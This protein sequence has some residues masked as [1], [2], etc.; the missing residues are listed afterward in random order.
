VPLRTSNYEKWEYYLDQARIYIA[1]DTLS[2][3]MARY[4]F[5]KGTFLF[6][7]KQDYVGTAIQFQL[8]KRLNPG[9]ENFQNTINSNLTNLY[10]QIKL[11]D[12][13]ETLIEKELVFSREKSDRYSE[14]FCL[15]GL[16]FAVL[17]LKKFDK[18]KEVCGDIF[19]LR[20][21][22]GISPAFGY[23]YYLLGEYYLGMNQL[24]SAAQIFQTGFAFSEKREEEKE[25]IDCLGG[26][27]RVN[28]AKEQYD[29]AIR[30]GELALT[31]DHRPE[32]HIEKHLASAYQEVGR[33][34]DAYELLLAYNDKNNTDDLER[35]NF[36]ITEQ[37]VEERFERDKKQV[38]LVYEQNLNQQ[39]YNFLAL[40]AFIALLLGLLTIILQARSRRRLKE[41][42]QSLLES[43]ESLRQFAYITSHDLKE[44]VRNI[45]SFSNLL[46]RRLS[47]KENTNDE[48]DFLTFIT[49]NA[50]VL[51]EIV[52]SL[53]IFT[54][55]SFGK[56]EKE[57][58]N[59]DEVFALLEN[60]L[61]QTIAEKN[62]VL[63][64]HESQ[65]IQ[66]I[67]FSRSMLILVLQNLI[68][69]GFKY[70]QSTQPR[71]E[72]AV[73]NSKGRCLMT[74]KDNGE[75]IESA[76]FEKI[77]KPFKTLKNKS[78]TQSSGLGLSICKNILERYNGRI[79]VES[80]GKNGS[81][82]FVLI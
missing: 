17:E 80:D 19:E 58:V 59:L 43:N 50:I 51:K 14:L 41:L 20:E 78:L 67:D 60:G 12:R 32:H 37:L 6:E 25:L 64:F 81:T 8:A 5:H 61:Q 44:P 4:H 57:E 63:L 33:Y 47:Q 76:Y 38:A 31:Y 9:D 65:E 70:N 73:K 49:S 1:D 39:R 34:K 55:I 22:T 30:N 75:G 72:V 56:I 48:K 26:I 62:G 77:F 36:I 45:T 2:N 7:A 15:Y 13:V 16:G 53:Q 82:F 35:D 21:K 27:I 40:T 18:L 24:D 52:D 74:I 10:G 68:I 71:V 23:A 11:F 54:N 28:L 42:N 69:N 79:W 46:S 29:E 3:T 66:Q